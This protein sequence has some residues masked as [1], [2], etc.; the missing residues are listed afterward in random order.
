MLCLHPA[1]CSLGIAPKGLAGK[2]RATDAA[3]GR[4][5]CDPMVALAQVQR[6]QG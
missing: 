6:P 3:G 4:A 2:K 5:A 1:V